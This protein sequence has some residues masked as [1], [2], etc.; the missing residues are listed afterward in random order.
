MEAMRGQV[1]NN[2]CLAGQAMTHWYQ[3]RARDAQY[4]VGDRGWSNSARRNSHER[5]CVAVSSQLLC[6]TPS[7]T[8]SFS[9]CSTKALVAG[10]SGDSSSLLGCSS[11]SIHLNIGAMSGLACWA[12][13]HRWLVS[14]GPPS[15]RIF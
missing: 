15:T 10:L 11:F 4:A 2:L 6:N 1:S 5:S 8:R 9:H 13:F 3:M 7:C 14:P 12:S